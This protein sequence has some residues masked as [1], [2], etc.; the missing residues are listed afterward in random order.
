MTDGM[1]SYWQTIGGL[2][3]VATWVVV[4]GLVIAL[5]QVIAGVNQFKKETHRR[6]QEYALEFS[7]T[8]NIAHIDARRDLA[9]TFHAT[10]LDSTRLSLGEIDAAIEND[11]DVLS[12]IRLL[13][14][15]WENMALAMRNKIADEDTA[16]EMVGFRVINTAFQ[17][18]AYI[19]KLNGESTY[20][21]KYLMWLA[22]SW[23]KKLKLR[24][25]V[26]SRRC[27]LKI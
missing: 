10:T 25:R 5:W 18:G 27:K 19:E 9:R 17:Y 20:S 16:M 22:D 3:G 12:N 2:P 7:L 11:S 21:Y 1:L 23:N 14:N 6:R 26:F 15:H 24:K 13:L 4:L 8:R